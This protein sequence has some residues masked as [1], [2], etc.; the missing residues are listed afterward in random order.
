[1]LRNTNFT[2]PRSNSGRFRFACSSPVVMR[3]CTHRKAPGRSTNVRNRRTGS[4][5][6][7][8]CD[9]RAGNA[10]GTWRLSKQRAHRVLS[11]FRA[12]A[13]SRAIGD[14]NA[15][16]SACQERRRDRKVVF[17]V[18]CET[19]AFPR[20]RPVGSRLSVLRLRS[21]VRIRNHRSGHGRRAVSHGRRQKIE[22]EIVCKRIF[23]FKKNTTPTTMQSRRASSRRLIA[24]R[25]DIQIPLQYDE[26][27][28]SSHDQ[29]A[30]K[31]LYGDDVPNPSQR[32]GGDNDGDVRRTAF[33][34]PNAIRPPPHDFHANAKPVTDA[35]N[36]GALAPV[37]IVPDTS[38]YA[39]KSP[40]SM[41]PDARRTR[42]FTV[43]APDLYMRD[44]TMDDRVPTVRWTD[45]NTG[46]TYQMYEN[47][48]PPPDRNYSTQEHRRGY[49][50]PHFVGL[51]GGYDPAQPRYPK[52]EV[53]KSLPGIADGPSPAGMALLQSNRWEQQLARAIDG[54][55]RKRDDEQPRNGGPERGV[56]FDAGGNQVMDMYPGG[57]V[58]VQPYF[59]GAVTP[60]VSFR[61]KR[62]DRPVANPEVARNAMACELLPQRDADRNPQNVRSVDNVSTGPLTPPVQSGGTSGDSTSACR[63]ER[64]QGVW[65]NRAAFDAPTKRRGQTFGDPSMQTPQGLVEHGQLLSTAHPHVARPA[66]TI[67]AQESSGT[68]RGLIPERPLAAQPDSLVSHGRSWASTHPTDSDHLINPRGVLPSAPPQ[69]F[70]HRTPL[71]SVMPDRKDRLRG[72]NDGEYHI[73]TVGA[74]DRRSVAPGVRG[75]SSYTQNH[76]EAPVPFSQPHRSINRDVFALA[77]GD[78]ACG[79]RGCRLEAPP[80]TNAPSSAGVYS[81]GSAYGG[82]PSP[83]VR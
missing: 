51:K 22:H 10:D 81:H 31:A 25:D 35:A 80:I 39:H 73:N 37:V 49:N 76:T 52:K 56:C 41:T 70:D 45:P 23:A 3:T 33:W 60:G 74:A 32:A 2:R 65:K 67:A 64:R 4:S 12:R 17:A 43:S 47:M 77:P 50:T 40:P 53:P 62:E 55:G 21:R 16:V 69:R 13:G 34:Q 27:C 42:P 66:V 29:Q 5:K 82:Y 28:R 59:R 75:E 20:C 78:R 36:A 44:P 46:V 19:D 26:L 24:D 54:A 38:D 30:C 68:V 83:C 1:M 9:G 15:N 63:P 8:F 72:R 48:P 14:W 11:R 18:A 6:H 58:G 61:Q 79:G 71:A 57:Y 7:R